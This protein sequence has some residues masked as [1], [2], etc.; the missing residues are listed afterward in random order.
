[1]EVKNVDSTPSAPAASEANDVPSAPPAPVETYQS[2]EC[3]VC[4]ENKVMFLLDQIAFSLLNDRCYYFFSAT[5]FSFLV[6][7]FAHAGNASR[8]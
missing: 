5:S 2:N 6:A 4:L 7:M 3:V 1:M 8:A